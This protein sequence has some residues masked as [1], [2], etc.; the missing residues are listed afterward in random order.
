MFFMNLKKNVIY[1][2][3]KLYLWEKM[4]EFKVI[5]FRSEI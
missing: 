3:E 2:L 5:I 1:N 4:K